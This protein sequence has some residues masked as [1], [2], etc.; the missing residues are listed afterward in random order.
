MCA[1]KKA[2]CCQKKTCED[3]PKENIAVG[4]LFE[5]VLE[6]IK[7]VG[8]LKNLAPNVFQTNYDQVISLLS[9]LMLEN[10]TLREMLPKSKE[11]APDIQV[12]DAAAEI[13]FGPGQKYMLRLPA[14]TPDAREK[15]AKTLCAAAAKLVPAAVSGNQ[16]FLPFD[17]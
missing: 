11:A 6:A 1:C 14:P 5:Q 4:V 15:L 17:N 9:A 2:T 12:N 7:T 8:H 16:M 3:L 13:F 10:Q